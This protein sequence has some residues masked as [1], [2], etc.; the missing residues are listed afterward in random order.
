[1]NLSA[2][3]TRQLSAVM[4]VLTEPSPCSDSLRQR[5]VEPMAQLLNADYVASLVWDADSARY[6]RGVCSRADA[7]HLR[8]YESQYQFSD[9]IAPRLHLRRYPTRVTQ[10]MPQKELVASEFFD[11]FLR[12]GAMY[13]GVNLYAHDGQRDVGDLRIWRHRAKDNFDD[14][15]LAVLRLLYPSLVN[16]FA[17]ANQGVAAAAPNAT[18]R[19]M[20]LQKLAALHGLSPREAQVV[21]LVA[22]GC[23]DKEIAAKAGVAY[24]TVRTYLT[25]A[26]RKTGCANRKALIAYACSL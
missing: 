5:L 11:R 16:A 12:P 21:Q 17:H 13:W 8:A 22:R 2:I 1:M 20:Q 25:Q 14:N 23:A 7:G 18:S 3:Q 6:G 10:V 15:E 26:L 4:Q 9:P 19:P 24:T